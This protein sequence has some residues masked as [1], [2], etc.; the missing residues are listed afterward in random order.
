MLTAGA[1]N[2]MSH[3]RQFAL[4]AS[5]SVACLAIAPIAGAT[6]IG[7]PSADNAWSTTSAVSIRAHSGQASGRE[8][9]HLID[10]G[11]ITG[12]YGEQHVTSSV[13]GTGS[14]GFS[15]FTDFRSPPP[16]STGLNASSPNPGTL[17]G[18]GSHW[19]EFMFDK[20]YSL[21]DVAIW[22]DNQ[23]V[24]DQGWKHLAVQVSTTGGTNASD[25]TT[26]FNG[27]LP[28]SPGPGSGYTG[29]HAVAS[30][31]LPAA[32]IRLN[33]VPARYVSFTN[34]G[35][36][37]E[38]SYLKAYNGYADP[39]NAILSE[40]RFNSGL[41]AGTPPPAQNPKRPVITYSLGP[42]VND[43]TAQQ[44]LDG[45]WNT[46]WVY[47]QTELNIA[48][49]HGLRA[50]WGGA[51]DD[52]TVT[53]I[54]SNPALY[55]YNI[56]DE[57]NASQFASLGA[58]VQ[59]LRTLDPN[60]ISYI[61]LLPSYNNNT[62]L[63]ANGYQAYLSQYM[64][65]V[66]PSLLSYD[67][68]PF[69]VYGDLPQYFRDLALISHTAK[70][71]GIPFMMISQA[72]SWDPEVRVPT[73]NEVR[74]QVYTTLA[75]GAQTISYYVYSFTNH[76][77]GMALGDGTPTPL[78][79][80][81]QSLNK[82]F[83]TIADQVQPLNSI[84]AYHLGD[85]PTGWGTS[86]GSSPMR[87]PA[88]S[89]FTLTPSVP[90]TTYVTN[91]PVKGIVLGMF[92]RGSQLADATYTLVVNLNYSSGT[93][94]T[95]NGPGNLSTFD[96]LTGVWSATGHPWASLN[97]LPG[98]GVL[99]GLTSAI[100]AGWNI[101]G[102]GSWHQTPSWSTL[103]VPNGI[104]A[105]VEFS[106]KITSPASVVIDGPVVAGRMQFNNVNSYVLGGTGSLTLQ[107]STGSASI[108]V[109][110]GSH[111][112]N[113]PSFFASNTAI[114]VA[115]GTTLT[116]GNPATIRAGK[117]VTKSGNL[118]IQAPLTI[119]AGGALVLASGPTIAFGAPSV[120]AGARIDVQGNSMTIDYRGQ[121]SPAAT[122]NAQLTSGYASGA[123]NGTGINTSSAVAGQ[124]A[125]GWK[126]DVA[127]QSILVK[128]TYYGDANL[129]GQVD[130]SDL[131]A[132][133]TAWQTSA[134]WSQG[135]FDYSGFVD[136]SDLGKLATNWQLGAS[137][138]PL[139]PRFE[140]ALAS[141]GLRG[142]SVPEPAML[143]L[144]LGAVPMLSSRRRCHGQQRMY[145]RKKP[146]PR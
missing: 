106:S 114:T 26:V 30:F 90:N 109:E 143:G 73:A 17:E 50:I 97:L 49:A 93:I 86:D 105:K 140:E 68:Y 110:T 104:D 84:G 8:I 57:P 37:D 144:V 61:N 80:A 116:I 124:T 129:D 46:V 95:V 125:L 1:R 51:L 74:Y 35:H 39:Y 54:R 28:E 22:N 136:I 47:S 78:Y 27:I 63:G 3:R 113:V 42:W 66:H 5:A 65:A 48:R 16:Y 7:N 77:G 139:G 92:G 108:S 14:T 60:H 85:L 33:G 41:I 135:D 142:V 24:F 25:W 138:A 145:R 19:V 55:A 34:T 43:T 103:A 20:I 96:A 82:E 79:T 100:P 146:L 15:T 52:A 72:A 11:G 115:G 88:G 134:V 32:V 128:Y 87:L 122:V 2:T 133:A 99:V 127:G 69:R 18:T 9:V 137:G 126:D 130:I 107:S 117:T 101:D 70:Q 56:V 10:G 141:L 67:F 75:Y 23:S 98:G 44:M 45:N 118:L 120:G 12:T 64:N 94:T 6:P 83:E 111:K 4:Y 31:T 121:G 76:Q 40:V 59:H 89:P 13:D 102:G 112:I 131:G 58:T 91:T 71:A 36:G 38:V 29:A 81:A 21:N 62:I 53:E 132:L 123:W 119:E